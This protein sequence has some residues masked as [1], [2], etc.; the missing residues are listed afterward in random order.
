MV[1]AEQMSALRDQMGD[2][3]MF[4]FVTDTG[5]VVSIGLDGA[6][7]DVTAQMIINRVPALIR[8]ACSDGYSGHPSNE[9]AQRAFNEWQNAIAE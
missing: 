8:Q 3:A 1:T 5:L 7:S 2:D 6:V 9:D 4:G